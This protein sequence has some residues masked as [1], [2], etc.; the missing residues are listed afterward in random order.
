MVRITDALVGPHGKLVTVHCK[1][2]DVPAG[3]VTA[4]NRSLADAIVAV[5][6][7]T[8]QVPIPGDGSLAFIKKLVG[9][10]SVWLVPALA[11]AAVG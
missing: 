9:L 6:E 4:E 5:P 7:V 1:I 10:Q 11:M 2:A 8:D 3:T